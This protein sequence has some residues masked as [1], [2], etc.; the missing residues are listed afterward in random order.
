M[1]MGIYMDAASIGNDQISL[2]IFFGTDE[3][4]ERHKRY[5]IMMG[6]DGI[7]GWTFYLIKSQEA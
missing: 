7:I 6:P 1:W 5:K 2:Q 3:Y 4:K